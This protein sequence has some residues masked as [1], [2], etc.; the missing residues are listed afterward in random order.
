MRWRADGGETKVKHHR[1][2]KDRGCVRTEVSQYANGFIVSIGLERQ[3]GG[4]LRISAY[5]SRVAN[6]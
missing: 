4:A 6:F 3:M 5:L 2:D 1:E